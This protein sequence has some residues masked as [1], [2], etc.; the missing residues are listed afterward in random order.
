MML[1]TIRPGSFNVAWFVPMSITERLM[2]EVAE[3]IFSDYSVTRVE[4]AGLSVYRKVITF[5]FSVYGSPQVHCF[6]NRCSLS[7]AQPLMVHQKELLLSRCLHS[8]AHCM[9]IRISE[10]IYARCVCN[11]S[12][13][14]GRSWVLWHTSLHTFLVITSSLC[15][16]HRHQ[17]A[18]S[19][20]LEYMC[21]CGCGGGG[22]G[23]G[24]RRREEGRGRREEWGGRRGKGRGEREE[25]GGKRGERRG[26][27]GGSCN[28]WFLTPYS[29]HACT[30]M[31]VVFKTCCDMN[32]RWRDNCF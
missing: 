22:G 27:D 10:Y 6:P 1:I 2:K 32:D 18:T 31:V 14:G 23:G 29:I 12:P 21:V 30:C 17:G 26:S 15:A 8:A 13:C 28:G 20:D 19:P 5:V 4:I 16:V 25:G 7:L 9:G 11:H 24:R 3:E